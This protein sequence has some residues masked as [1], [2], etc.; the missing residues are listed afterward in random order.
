[1]R[2]LLMRLLR[3]LGRGFREVKH[4]LRPLVSWVVWSG[5]V[6]DRF[7]FVFVRLGWVREIENRICRYSSLRS[8]G[9]HCRGLATH[10]GRLCGLLW[11]RLISRHSERL[12]I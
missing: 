6:E 2:I 9:I 1:M 4:E 7:V 5:E 10:F 12:S 11:R 3:Y 8:H